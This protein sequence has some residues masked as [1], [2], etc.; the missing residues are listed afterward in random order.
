MALRHSGFFAFCLLHRS[1]GGS[2]R[3]GRC[4]CRS[5]GR[6]GFLGFLGRVLGGGRGGSSRSGFGRSR[7]RCHHGCGGRRRGRSLHVVVGKGG[8]GYGEQGGKQY[9]SSLGHG[10]LLYIEGSRFR[11]TCPINVSASHCV[12]LA[13]TQV[14][15][16]NFHPFARQ[17]R[18]GGQ[19]DAADGRTHQAQGRVADGGGHA[20]HLAVLA[21]L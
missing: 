9:D 6:G 17:Q 10:G 13:Q 18:V 19:G 7:R 16:R 15:R 14:V 20:A 2:S 1:G 11:R 4:C 5:G 12:D 21:F 8:G 3:G